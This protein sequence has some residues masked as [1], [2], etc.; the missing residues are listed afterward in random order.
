MSFFFI[1]DG[2]PVELLH[3]IYSVMTCSITPLQSEVFTPHMHS[4]T[5]DTHLYKTSPASPAGQ[6]PVNFPSGSIGHNEVV[7]GAPRPAGI[8]LM[9]E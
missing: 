5:P 9:S 8:S 4:D 3:G 1:Y 7:I 6:P 2:E